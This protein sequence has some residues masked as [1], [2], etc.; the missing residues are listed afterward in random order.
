M[1]KQGQVDRVCETLVRER[2]VAAQLAA[3]AVVNPRSRQAVTRLSARDYV[4]RGPELGLDTDSFDRFVQEAVPSDVLTGWERAGTPS[5][6]SLIR[7]PLILGWIGMARFLFWTRRDLLGSTIAFLGTVGVG[8][9]SSSAR[10]RAPAR[11]RCGPGVRL[12]GRVRAAQLGAMSEVPRLPFPPS[13]A[14]G[15][16]ALLIGLTGCGGEPPEQL[17][18]FEL[19]LT[20]DEMLAAARERGGFACRLR[21][22]RPKLAA[23]E[24]PTE[25]GIVTVTARADTVVRIELRL[26]PGA[27]DDPARAVRR[28]AR[29]FGDPAWRDRPLPPRATT[30]ERYHTLWLDEDTTRSVALACDGAE[31]APPCTAELRPTSPAAVRARRDTLLGILPRPR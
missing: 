1:R 3:G 17:G 8:L 2:L 22:S 15:A 25:D 19:G 12:A 20:Q 31:L 10:A 14:A 16:L 27:D 7:G 24:G 6:W 23:C 28:F 18:G 4:T 11:T 21:S 30:P 13:A 5:T 29:P 9:G 26:A